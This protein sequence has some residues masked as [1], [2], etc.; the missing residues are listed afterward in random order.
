VSIRDA[1]PDDAEAIRTVHRAS[2]TGLGPQAYD[3]EQV[4]AWARG[5]ADADYRAAIQSP[6]LDYVVAEQGCEVVGFG[7]LRDPAPDHSDD[8]IDAEITA[9]YVHPSVAREGVGSRIADELE[10]RARDADATILGLTA[11]LPAVPFYASRGYERV[12]ER[13][14]EF[15]A[16]AG[17]GVTGTVVE[18]RRPL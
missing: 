10:I 18:M 7:S 17:T 16:G 8:V 14:H 11:S 4:A 5:C 9:V 2:I 6:E 12:E 13:T 1:V 15:S 3:D